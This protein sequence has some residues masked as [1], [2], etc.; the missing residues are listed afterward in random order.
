MT[1]HPTKSNMANLSVMLA[2]VLMLLAA[3]GLGVYAYVIPGQA[4]ILVPIDWDVRQDLMASNPPVNNLT[5]KVSAPRHRLNAMMEAGITYRPDPSAFLEGTVTVP[6][7]LNPKDI[8]RGIKVLSLQPEELTFKVEQKLEKEVFVLV[9]LAG[10]PASGYTVT[11]L[12]VEPQRVSLKGPAR[13][14]EDKEV[15]RTMPVDISLARAPLTLEI[16]LALSEA[17]GDVTGAK[18]VTATVVVEE[19]K[20]V[21]RLT[22]PVVGK[23]P[24]RHFD[25][26]P[27]SIELVVKGPIQ[28]L[29]SL[30]KSGE[31][32]SWIDL[33][34]LGKGVY[35]R[36][37]VIALPLSVTLQDASP[38]VFTV[39][40]K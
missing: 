22:V 21:R 20:G 4:E 32:A 18:T 36:R 5:L 28:D 25:I 31:M 35:A 30:P 9:M 12:S 27:H 17:I 1:Q 19:E 8:S 10:Q 26:T 3:M 24:P 13:L 40:I 2:V 15:V 39:Q 29:D 6:V 16:P 37:A 34:G 11:E 33:K 7:Q 23:N 14:M 38:E